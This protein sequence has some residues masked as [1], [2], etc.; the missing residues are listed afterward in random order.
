MRKLK[1]HNPTHESQAAIMEANVDDD[2]LSDNADD[3]QTT[4]G[5]RNGRCTTSSLTHV[6]D[7][8]RNTTQ[9]QAVELEWWKGKNLQWYLYVWMF[10]PG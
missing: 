7:D 9:R 10:H 8:C 6:S 3:D 4:E 1:P 2:K 5:S